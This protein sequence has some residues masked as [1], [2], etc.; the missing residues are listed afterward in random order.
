VLHARAGR[1]AEAVRD[2]RAALLIDTKAPT[3]YQVAGIYAH[4][5]KR[6]A[7]DRREALRLLWAAVKTGYGLADVPTDPDLD[8][9]RDDPEFADILKR[10]KLRADL[11]R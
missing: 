9:I 1:R 2:A 10:A 5:A 6:N 8:P 4:S 3:L 7:D 11:G